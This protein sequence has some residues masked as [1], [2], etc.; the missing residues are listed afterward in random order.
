MYNSGIRPQLGILQYRWQNEAYLGAA[1]GIAGILQVFLGLQAYW[2]NVEVKGGLAA[3]SV[4]SAVHN[5]I[6]DC[7]EK[8]LLPSG[9]MMTTE[10]EPSD[11]LVHWCHGAPGFIDVAILSNDKKRAELLGEVVW[12]RGLLRKGVGLCHGISGNAY[13]FLRL[14]N[15]TQNKKWLNAAHWF[16]KFSVDNLASLQNVPDRPFSLFE[17]LLGLAS[18]LLDM[19]NPDRAV[20]PGMEITHLLLKT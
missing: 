5:T 1:H 9:N 18:V 15:Y 16:V 6:E 11:K 12:K 3:N 8:Y 20:F 17:G 2:P 13:S 14:Y 19:R 7:F 10:T 4:Y